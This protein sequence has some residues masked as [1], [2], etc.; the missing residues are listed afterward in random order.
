MARNHNLVAFLQPLPSNVKQKSKITRVRERIKSHGLFYFILEKAGTRLG[1]N[2]HKD[3]AEAKK[4]LLRDVDQVAAKL[5]IH[6]IGDI[7]SP[8]AIEFIKRLNVDAVICH[9]G[10][11]YREP[12]TNSLY[13]SDAKLSHRHITLV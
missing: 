7:N 5:P 3:F 4:R 11:I 6:K 1:W 12:S 2:E 10:P 9:G 8:E 13:P